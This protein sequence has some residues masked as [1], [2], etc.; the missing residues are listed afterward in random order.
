MSRRAST[1]ATAPCIEVETHGPVTLVTLARPTR[2]NAV[3]REMAAALRDALL[4]FERDEKARVAVLC[5]KGAAFCAGADLSAFDDPERRNVVTPDGSGDGPMGLTRRHLDKPVIAAISGHA[6]AGGLELALW[7]DLRV[8]DDSATFGVFCRRFGVPLI[9][10]GTVRLPRL[11]GMSRALDMI[12]TGRAVGAQEAYEIGLV[13][14][15]VPEGMALQGALA[16]AQQLAELPQGALRADRRAAY[17]QWDLPLEAALQREGAA[18]HSVVFSE[19]IAGARAFLS[20]AG[21]HGAP[22]DT[23]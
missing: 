11:I 17:A 22:R 18:G 20:G 6:V 13:N 19:G 1:S 2:R 10:G 23:P 15:L 3:D 5:G 4:A 9:D 16:L 8:A 12:L 21:R 14:R 7:C